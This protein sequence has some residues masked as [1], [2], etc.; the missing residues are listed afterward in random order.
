MIP[1][2]PTRRDIDVLVAVGQMYLQAL[3]DDPE[4]EY[5]ILPEAMLVTEVCEAVERLGG[6]VDQ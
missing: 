4:N 5:L 6:K 3:D 1:M 2:I